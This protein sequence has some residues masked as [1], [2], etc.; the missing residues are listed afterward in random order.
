MDVETLTGLLKEAE[1]HHGPYEASA[2]PHHWSGFYAAYIVARG[3][4]R[5]PEEADAEARRYMEG[6]LAEQGN[7]G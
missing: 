4:G 6:V 5:T 7:G 1:E 3:E 2:P